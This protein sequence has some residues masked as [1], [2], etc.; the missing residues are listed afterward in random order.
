MIGPVTDIADP[1]PGANFR[2]S[3][4]PTIGAD[5][6]AGSTTVH[7]AWATRTTAGGRIVVATSTDR[8]ATWSAPVTVS[9][10][11]GYAFF[12]G[13]DVA[14]DG[15][16]DVAYQ[17]LVAV[18][19][20]TFGTGNATVDAYAV[21]R[22]PGGTWSA[23]VRLTAV[24]SDPAVSAQNNLQRQFWGDYTTVVS[25]ATGAWFV[26]TDSR[27]GSGCTDVDAYQR[28]L[29]DNGL[30]TR[31][32]M[33]DRL[34]QR[35]TGINPALSDPSVKPAPPVVCPNQFGNT[36]IIVARFRP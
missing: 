2:T 36:D 3:S 19:P 5:P 35:I 13:L 16:I 23:P 20:T 17:A 1:I 18:D 24:S 9:R 25:D 4:F 8:G 34:S 15:R 26:Y 11:E 27:T 7:A 10:T 33:A 28:Y 32:D 29:R 6:R 30:A 14:P 12:P 31:G 21:T 22:S